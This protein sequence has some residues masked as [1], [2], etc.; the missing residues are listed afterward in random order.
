M[1]ESEFKY[2]EARRR[3]E[4][5]RIRTLSKANYRGEKSVEWHKINQL[6]AATLPEFKKAMKQADK[7]WES[8]LNTPTK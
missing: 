8:L 4:A 2:Y 5:A 7:E 1:T 6:T 3:E